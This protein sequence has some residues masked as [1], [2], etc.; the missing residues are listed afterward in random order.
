MKAGSALLRPA[1][2]TPSHDPL[3]PLHGLIDGA[4]HLVKVN[5]ITA[6]FLNLQ[7]IFRFVGW[8]LVL[9]D[10]NEVWATCSNTPTHVTTMSR[11]QTP[12]YV[13]L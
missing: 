3:V 8:E 10:S 1:G 13:A 12:V 11:R 6:T 4:P 7:C 2:T 5:A 9:G